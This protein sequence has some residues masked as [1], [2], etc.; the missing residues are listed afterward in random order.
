MECRQIQHLLHETFE[1]TIT[2]DEQMKMDQHLTQCVTCQADA[3]FLQAVVQALDEA[4]QEQ[5]SANFTVEVMDRLP[6]PVRLFGFIPVVVFRMMAAAIGLI[7]IAFGWVY[8]ATLLDA[9]RS[10]TSAA[11]QPGPVLEPFQH[12]TAYI[13]N[14][15][16]SILNH[17][18]NVDAVW[19]APT[20][21]IIIAIGIAH[22]IL[23]MVDGFE[24]SEWDSAIDQTL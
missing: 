21:S 18:P 12:A 17:I 23:S 7:A 3:K 11:T 14:A 9:A 4:P 22:V 2:S 1:R 15:W 6:A 13:Y 19:L 5:P 16:V 20:I 24:P 8:Q 10:L